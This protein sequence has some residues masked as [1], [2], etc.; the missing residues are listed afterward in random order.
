MVVIEKKPTQGS[1]QNFSDY[2]HSKR[3]ITIKRLQCSISPTINF[4]SIQK[5]QIELVMN[6][7]NDRRISLRNADLMRYHCLDC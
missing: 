2:D 1:Q 5:E 4:I 6:T 7:A 3:V